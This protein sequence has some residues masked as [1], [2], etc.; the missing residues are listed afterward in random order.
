MSPTI[1]IVHEFITNFL[2]FRQIIFINEGRFLLKGEDK[3]F[4]KFIPPDRL[5]IKTR[6]FVNR[7]RSCLYR[8]CKLGKNVYLI[9]EEMGR[10]LI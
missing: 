1:N 6:F 10:N 2:F 8:I 3:N 5:S 4:S 7:M 9:F